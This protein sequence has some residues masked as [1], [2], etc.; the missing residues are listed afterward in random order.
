[1]EFILSSRDM[2]TIE[3][4]IM[5]SHPE[6]NLLSDGKKYLTKE[7]MMEEHDEGNELEKERYLIK[8]EDQYIGIIDF[9]MENPRDQMPWLGLL[10]IHKDWNNKSLA[11]L[12]LSKY[13]EIMRSRNIS[14]VRLG[15]YAENTKGIHFWKNNGFI[16]I[17]E[18]IL[19]E[20]QLW[21]MS[22]LLD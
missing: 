8:Y 16:K 15:C 2:I 9:I 7:D 10:I 19:N 17:K 1:M 5:N 22:K 18:V 14:E 12:A 20:K 11:K 21:I 6:Y 13:V 3:L 4:D